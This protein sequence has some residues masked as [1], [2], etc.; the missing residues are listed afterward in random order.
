MLVA[1]I[2]KASELA[3]GGAQGPLL[4]PLSLEVAVVA[5]EFV[6]GVWIIFGLFPSATRRFTIACFCL[7]ACVALYKM[8]NG[9]YS[10][11]CFGTLSPAPKYTLAFDLAVIAALSVLR[12]NSARSALPARVL[13][14]A[15]GFFT[16]AIW[17]GLAIAMAVNHPANPLR[18]SKFNPEDWIGRCLPLLEHIDVAETLATGRWTIVFFREDCAIC[19]KE[20]TRYKEI[21]SNPSARR[22]WGRIALIELP[23]F[24]SSNGPPVA[25]GCPYVVGRLEGARRWSIS[26]PTVISTVD[27]V[28]TPYPRLE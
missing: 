2:L 18:E 13:P 7:Y 26:T 17:G 11:G 12:P 4:G 19:K 8:L 10:C 9:A 16:V 1:S 15:L 3:R 27:C 25:D 20:T 28:I 21:A 6:S 5:F 22:E 23:P 14:R 24:S